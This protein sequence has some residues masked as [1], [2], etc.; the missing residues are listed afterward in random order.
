MGAA[1]DN[2]AKLKKGVGVT[3]VLTFFIV[4]GGMVSGMT[5]IAGAW[6]GMLII[7][8]TVAYWTKGRALATLLA[9]S[10]PNAPGADGPLSADEEDAA[11]RTVKAQD[12]E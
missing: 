6:A 11:D 2:V 9:P 4:V 7:G 1:N 8:I 10:D 5:P 12:M 3:I